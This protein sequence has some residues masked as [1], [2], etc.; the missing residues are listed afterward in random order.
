[1][2]KLARTDRGRAALDQHVAAI[3]EIE[4]DERLS[5]WQGG[6]PAVIAVD[7]IDGK[8]VVLDQVVDGAPLTGFIHGSRELLTLLE[9]AAILLA[10]FHRRTASQRL[11]DDELVG[12]L[13]HQPVGTL[14]AH[15]TDRP[16][17]IEALAVMEARLARELRGKTVTVSRIHGDFAPGNILLTA[18]GDSVAGII[19]WDQARPLGLPDVDL[20]FLL[21][22]TRMVRQRRELGN[23]VVSL[24]KRGVFAEWEQTLLSRHGLNTSLGLST[25][26]LVQLAWLHHVASNLSK[27]STYGNHD[28]WLERNVGYVLQ[29]R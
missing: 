20:V 14:Q 19:D 15:I 1:M 9:P 4:Q 18:A 10:D 6:V 7:E 17:W 11:A 26:T 29:S 16:G 2:L 3:R 25:S 24:R 12:L 8:R 28:M 27:A 21:L 22:A 23:V 5:D 13:V